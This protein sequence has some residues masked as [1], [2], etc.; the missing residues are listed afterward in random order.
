MSAEQLIADTT[1]DLIPAIYRQYQ[2]QFSDAGHVYKPLF[3]VC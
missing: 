3:C 2:Y 1:A